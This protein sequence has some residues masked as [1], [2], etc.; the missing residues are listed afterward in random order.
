MNR[1]RVDVATLRATHPLPEVVA[2]GGVR[3]RA[4]GRG[5]M[6]C[7]PFHDD[8]T[9]SLSVDGVPDRFHCFGCGATGD[10]IDFVQRLYGLTFPE[11]VA[12]L[13]G[14]TPHP[15]LTQPGR[16]PPGSMVRQVLPECP[17][18]PP[19]DRA[20]EVNALAFA[21]YARPVAHATAVSH[22]RRRRGIDVTALETKLGAAVVG[23]T[24]H[25]WTTLT[26]HLR[27]AGVTDDELLAL[28]LA[29]PTRRGTLIDTLRDRLVVPV[30]TGD[31]R[32]AGLIGR[33]T[34]GDPRAPKYRNPTRTTTYDKA[35][36]CYQPAPTRNPNA[37]VVLVEGP[38]DA[39]AVAATTADA[40][41]LPEFTALTAGGVAVTA[42][43][44]AR[45]AHLTEGALV[46]G[47][48]GDTAGRDG[49]TRWVDHLAIH[50]GRPVL[51]ADLP[52]GRD[53]GDWLAQH[54]PNGLLLLDPAHAGAPGGPRQAGPEIV[55]ATL[56]RRPRDPVHAVFVALQ[57]LLAALPAP[58][59]TDLATGA[60]AEMTRQ[61]WN[62]DHAFARALADAPLARSA[63]RAYPTG[64]TVT[65][66]ALT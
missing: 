59:A 28:D 34:S 9:A 42:A 38:V 65:G 45:A 39:L 30:T 18:W 17:A 62:P 22:L 32:I 2:A 26:D 46:V 51:V 21:H 13:Q 54:G 66:P 15:R 16:R 40:G 24:G 50:A 25:G 52:T 4:Q 8:T 1:P 27:D 61:G 47:M 23:H 44:A 3:L 48:D 10:V 43:H 6:G 58:Q 12:H 7:C 64:A 63:D 36:T 33:D 57:P 5:W 11:A 20:H 41:R 35:T 14:Q 29:Q 31:G 56:A 60:T 53:P 37:T 55:R 19:P 49:T